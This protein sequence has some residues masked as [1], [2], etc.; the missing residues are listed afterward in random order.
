MK[1]FLKSFAIRGFINIALFGLYKDIIVAQIMSIEALG[2]LA[3]INDVKRIIDLRAGRAYL[4]EVAGN[5]NAAKKVVR[6]LARIMQL[7]LNVGEVK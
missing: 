6:F 3:A 1:K 2:A 5:K 4:I 7:Y